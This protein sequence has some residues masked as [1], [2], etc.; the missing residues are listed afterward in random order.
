MLKGINR[1]LD[2]FRRPTPME[3]LRLAQLRE[4]LKTKLKGNDA[5]VDREI[6]VQRRRHPDASDVELYAFSTVVGASWPPVIP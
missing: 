3:D 5:A 4:N 6:E 2:R 1:F